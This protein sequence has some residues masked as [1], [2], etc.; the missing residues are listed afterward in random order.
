MEGW[1][2]VINDY[3]SS[4]VILFRQS[5]GLKQN[6]ILDVVMNLKYR[7]ISY[8]FFVYEKLILNLKI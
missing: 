7:L 8:L 3:G 5:D 6:A 2:S 1:F 4:Y